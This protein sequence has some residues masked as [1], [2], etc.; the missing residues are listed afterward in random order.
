MGPYPNTCS[1]CGGVLSSNAVGGLCPRCLARTAGLDDSILP[2]ESP[3][4]AAEIAPIVADQDDLRIERELARGGMGVVYEAQQPAIGRS[5]VVKFLRA[6][7]AGDATALERFVREGRI[8]GQLEHPGIVPIYHLGMNADGRPFYAM[9]HIRGAS[10]AQVLDK[11][12]HE[13]PET[14]A[15]YPLGALLNAFQK[16][17][18]AVAYAHSRGVIHRDLKPDNVMIGPFGEVVVMDWGLAKTLAGSDEQ[19]EALLAAETSSGS[20]LETGGTMDHIVMG[21][22]G[23]MAPE[24]AHGQSNQADER[25]DV[26]ALGAILYAILTL[27]PPIRGRDTELMLDRTRAGDIRPPTDYNPGVRKEVISLPLHHCLGRKI[28]PVL[29]TVAMKALALNPGERYQTVAELQQDVAAYQGGFATSAE[30]AGALRQFLL[31]LKRHKA[32]SALS[33]LIVVSLGAVVGQTLWSNQRMK[34][35]LAQ[36]RATAPALYD[37]ARALVDDG[38]LEEALG[39]ADYAIS[40]LPREG[41]Y[42]EL[43]GN[44]LQT[45]L[46]FREAGEAYRE[47]LKLT[48]TL[49]FAAT[50]RALC[51]KLMA[52]KIGEDAWPT[53]A[54]L[55]LQMAMQEQGRPSEALALIPMLKQEEQKIFNYWKERL[56]AAGV[57]TKHLAPTA[58]GPGI[59]FDHNEK[60]SDADLSAL[61][62]MP[63]VGLEIDNAANITTIAPLKGMP[64]QWLSFALSRVHDLAPLQGM[65]TLRHLGIGFAPVSD[66]T[67]LKGLRLSGLI[68]NN[69][70]VRDLSPLRGM[71][72]SELTVSSTRVADLAPLQGMPLQRLDLLGTRITNITQLAGLPLKSLRLQDLNVADLTPLKGMPLNF[73]SLFNTRVSD[74]SP[75]AGMP[76]ETLEL[77]GKRITDITVLHGMPLKSLYLKG[78]AVRDFSPL[79]GMTL[80]YLT[81][82]FTAFSELRLLEGLPLETLILRGAHVTDIGAIQSMPKLTHLD[83]SESPVVDLS[84]LRSARLTRLSLHKTRVTGISALSGQP[85]KELTLHDCPYLRDLSPLVAC[86]QLERLTLPTAATNV[87]SLRDLPALR[88]VSYQP[89]NNGTWPDNAAEF[90]RTFDAR[91]PL[92]K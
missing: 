84:P 68:A 87:Q 89:S 17:C 66:L 13:D 12:A 36:L 56:S 58:A 3:S 5:V 24:Q 90:W 27:R 76:L 35:T 50:N 28:P 32:I 73:L 53:T 78:T 51:E 30:R 31:L 10:L 33:A 61:R 22:L 70:R 63:L 47:A 57:S 62:G 59:R 23:F 4:T 9:R 38:Q 79:R 20:P 83:L 21:T 49:R 18:D 88:S 67:P 91:Q 48:P 64:L 16:L 92:R 86:P 46:R 44:I 42:H 65:A 34:R 25:T 82:E 15:R 69:T 54:L 19:S 39:R 41:S 37:K 26:Y 85:L 45:M 71:R 40:L 77:D 72:L 6:E 43:R 8:T 11:L 29:S 55:E 81:V 60:I 80:T 14:I 1:E 74:L 75:L 2:E 7:R 52:A